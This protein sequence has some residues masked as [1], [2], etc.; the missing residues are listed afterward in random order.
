MIFLSSCAWTKHKICG[1]PETIYI[2]RTIKTEE[3]PAPKDYVKIP[4]IRTQHIGSVDNVNILTR[5][6]TAQY[7]YISQ[8]QSV[9][10]CYYE[11]TLTPTQGN[12]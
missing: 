10:K 7:E 5:N 3:C 9:L 2:D 12:K 4:L 6:I 1:D 8:I 11:Q